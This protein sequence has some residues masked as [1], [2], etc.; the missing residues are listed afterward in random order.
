MTL[1][2]N[3]SLLTR[4]DYLDLPMPEVL[5]RHIGYQEFAETL[6]KF[7][8]DHELPDDC[9]IFATLLR[10]IASGNDIDPKDSHYALAESLPSQ[11]NS[12]CDK[13]QFKF[14]NI[15]KNDLLRFICFFGR[16]VDTS[17][18]QP[19][20][21]HDAKK[22]IAYITFDLRTVN[23][24]LMPAFLQ[25]FSSLSK[26][27]LDKYKEA[28]GEIKIN[29][30]C[31]D[32]SQQSEHLKR[33]YHLLHGNEFAQG[34]CYELYNLL[35]KGIKDIRLNSY[36]SDYQTLKQQYDLIISRANA[37]HDSVMMMFP[38][39]PQAAAV[40][41]TVSFFRSLSRKNKA[42]T[43]ESGMTDTR[44]SLREPH[45]DDSFIDLERGLGNK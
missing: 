5:S 44:A 41:D 26:E 45:L 37:F 15:Q 18:R 30:V 8:A 6:G 20:F 3:S 4:Q 27:T 21:W 32:L 16:R 29:T 36:Q 28:Y 10:A 2:K 43:L 9:N 7:N 23:D 34:Q 35:E 22:N 39:Q 12:R 25:A 17:Y 14:Y 11:M 31:H 1:R 40:T 42:S 38:S 24:F 33:D 13:M 19:S